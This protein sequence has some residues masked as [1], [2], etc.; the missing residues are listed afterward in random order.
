MS[1][2]RRKFSV[3]PGMILGKGLLRE[4]ILVQTCRHFRFLLKERGGLVKVSRRPA[5]CWGSM[6]PKSRDVQV[7]QDR[8]E[9]RRITIRMLM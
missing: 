2:C 3:V 6:I 4:G 1:V 7:K 9:D 5:C 8:V